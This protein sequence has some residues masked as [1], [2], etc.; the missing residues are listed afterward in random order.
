MA[1]LQKIRNK[2]GLLIGALGIALLAFVLGD[3][4]GSGGTLFNK[5]KDKAFVVDGDVVSTGEYM[6]RVTEFEEFQKMMS[7]QSSIDENMSGQIKEFVYEQMVKEKI[8]DDQAEKLGLAVSTEELTDMAFGENV[9]PILLQSPLFADPQTGQFSRD[10]L[11][12]LLTFIRTD[13]NTLP[14][15]QRAQ[16]QMFSS[17]WH[18]IERMMKYY[19]LEE[20]Y[21]ALL[22]SAL[23]TNNIEVQST[24]DNSNYNSTIAYVVNRYS[25]IPDSAVSVSDKEIEKLYNERKNNY[26]TFS[27]Q[28]KVSYFTKN[29]VP[30]EEDYADV[31]KEINKVR[32][33]LLTTTNPAL[34]VADYSEIPY[35]NIFSSESSLNTEEKSFVESASIG[36]VHGPIREDGAYYLYKL[37]DKTQAPDSISMKMISIPLSDEVLANNIADSLVSVIKGGKEFSV[38]ANE[39]NPQSNGGEIGWVTEINLAS[40]GDDFVRSCFAASKG[41]ILKLKMQNILQL[42]K[43]ED[44][45]KVVPKVKLATIKMSVSVSD[46]TLYAIDTELNQF[47]AEHSNDT[48]FEKSARDKG[49]SLIS[50]M[51]IIPSNINLSQIKGSRQVIFWAFNE[52]VGSVKK[53]D[54]PDQRVVAKIAERV[55]AGYLPLADVSQMLKDELIKDK[56]AE[57]VIAD[58]KTKNVSTLEA[59]A[60][61]LNT[62]VDTVR[63]VNFSIPSISGLG[64][65]PLLN[66]SSKYS[67]LNKVEGPAKGNSGVLIYSV[68]DRKEMP[69]TQNA[70]LVK[71]NLDRAYMY[72]V[73]PSMLFDVLKEKMNVEDNRIRFF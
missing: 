22:T 39:I 14:N 56:K 66:V 69:S 62:R 64:R 63:F 4:L 2:A 40:A 10:G 20:K 25:L 45:K 73:N 6:N 35:H 5:W 13:I 19:R 21:N 31:E 15:E 8:L 11:T 33:S 65:E 27:E 44:V 54:L 42:V 71:S 3:F 29:I 24:I 36:D 52:K 46:K 53:F 7:G 17:V 51:P 23:T 59:Y 28:A 32:E 26:K 57:K 37:I 1:A 72:R 47:V 43:I 61:V 70:E 67:E 41:D 38:V 30:S 58:L 48:D 60:G 9:S 68:V 55:D 49:Y 50:N 16:H 34:L 18:M 12:Q